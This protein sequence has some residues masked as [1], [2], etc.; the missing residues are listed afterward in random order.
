MTSEISESFDVLSFA[1]KEESDL[2]PSVKVEV[3]E[4]KPMLTVTHKTASGT[5]SHRH[6]LKLNEKLSVSIRDGLPL[7][8][9]NR[10]MYLA[11]FFGGGSRIP[12]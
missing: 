10:Y 12:R 3:L 9:K 2:V 6:P 7:L 11:F 5:V 1:N 8:A 4:N